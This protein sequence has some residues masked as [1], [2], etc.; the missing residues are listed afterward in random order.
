[1]PLPQQDLIHILISPPHRYVQNHGSDVLRKQAKMTCKYVQAKANL[2]K[3][4]E[5]MQNQCYSPIKKKKKRNLCVQFQAFLLLEFSPPLESCSNMYA[6]PTSCMIMNLFYVLFLW[7]FPYFISHLS[8]SI[9]DL[10]ISVLCTQ[11]EQSI[12][13]ILNRHAPYRWLAT[14][15]FWDSVWHCAQ[16]CFFKYCLLQWFPKC[17]ISGIPDHYIQYKLILKCNTFFIKS[18][19]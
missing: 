17:G 8:L 11:I 5:T 15:V 13:R 1:M 19:F 16:K 18:L 14:S 10:L 3:L 2:D 9:V 12:I 6:G 4:C 7:Y